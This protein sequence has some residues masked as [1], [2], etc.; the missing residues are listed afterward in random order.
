MGSVDKVTTGWRARWRT[1][2]GASRSKTFARQVDANNHLTTVEGSKLRGDYVDPRAGRVTFAAWVE[3]WQA[4][5][6]DLRP[7]TVARDAGYVGRYLVPAFGSRRLSE[8][9]TSA[10]RAWVAGLTAQGLA[11]ATVV[12]AGQI[13]GKAMATAVAD[14]L[15]AS[16]PCM[17][18]RLPRIERTEMRF[19]SPT[20]VDSL[21]DAID[22]RCRALVFLGAYG[23]LRIGELLGLRAKRVDTL[24]GR[25]DVAEILVEVEGHLHY[26]APKTRAGRRSVPLPRI[27]VDAVTEHLRT[28]PSGPADLIFRAP[29][30][31]PV[32]LASWRKR[33][34]SPAVENAGLEHFTPHGLRHTAVAFWIAAGAGPKE[35]ATWAGHS[36]VSF[37]LD[38]YG[39]LM[40]GAEGRVLEALDAL[41]TRDAAPT[42]ATVV[43]IAT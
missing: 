18:V 8:I 22:P 35:I 16:S 6:V 23:G 19:L 9:D 30:G 24:R 20:E 31:G 13:M 12:K 29:E 15:I 14:G 26:G 4:G 37:T 2:D 43:N 41:A 11:P 7:S 34:W 21:A 28:Y 5:I 1:P 38:R 25:V 39:H 33:V 10:V 17:G 32:R 36:S 27:A 3:R 40:A 42:S